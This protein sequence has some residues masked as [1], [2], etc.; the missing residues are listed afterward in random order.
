M[1][2]AVFLAK[3]WS[4]VVVVVFVLDPLRSFDRHGSVSGE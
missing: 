4:P 1:S 2:A 3:A